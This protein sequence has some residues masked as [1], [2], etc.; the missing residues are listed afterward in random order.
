[1]RLWEQPLSRK[2]QYCSQ[3]WAKLKT[4]Y[5]YRWRLQS[6]GKDSIVLRPLFWTPEF[7]SIGRN[8]F[9]WPGCRIEGVEVG[10]RADI[11]APRI[12]IGDGVTIQQ[13][14]HITAGGELRIESGSTILF[15]VMIT[16][17]DHRYEAVGER[18]IDQPM[19]VT[20][21]KI[22][23]NCFIGSG[24]KILAGTT[25]GDS[26]VVA[27]NSVVRGDFPAGAVIAGMPGRIVKQYDAASR[28][29]ERR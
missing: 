2:I 26:C 14:C 19:R 18:V 4:R 29:W 25:L 20:S 22:G 27:A 17:I 1:M 23:R 6:C 16:D 15:D 21:T 12:T 28:Q 11:A 24:A 8:V 3:V 13:Y 9:I 5:V 10:E 7:V